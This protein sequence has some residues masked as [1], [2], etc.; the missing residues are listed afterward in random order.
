[1]KNNLMIGSAMAVVVLGLLAAI[2]SSVTLWLLSIMCIGVFFIALCASATAIPAALLGFTIASIIACGV[3]TLIAPYIGTSVSEDVVVEEITV[4]KVEEDIESIPS[5]PVAEIDGE[6]EEEAIAVPDAPKLRLTALDLI[7]EEGEDL[8][9]LLP[10]APE[11]F[12]IITSIDVQT[13]PVP[14][15]AEMFFLI[16][17]IS[18]EETDEKTEVETVVPDVPEL[19]WI[20]ES[21]SKD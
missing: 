11:M 2:F 14:K 12:S 17:S 4:E 7:T 19:F 20:I 5:V 15:Q 3:V 9:L 6:L 18:L 16:D 21:I 10:S 8:R 13:V 1:M